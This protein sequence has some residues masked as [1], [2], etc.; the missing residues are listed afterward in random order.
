MTLYCILQHIPNYPGL[1]YVEYDV[2]PSLD[3]R[4]LTEN[5]RFYLGITNVHIFPWHGL[6]FTKIEFSVSRFWRF[7]Q[8]FWKW[9]VM[10]ACKWLCFTTFAGTVL[11]PEILHTLT[12]ELQQ[13]CS[14]GILRSTAFTRHAWELLLYSCIMGL[15]SPAESVRRTE[16]M[17]D[18]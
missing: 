8:D 17:C 18:E 16:C 12:A 5:L 2:S 13:L 15:T 9:T 4:E 14:T 3:G 10:S 11:R 6:F 1:H 7:L